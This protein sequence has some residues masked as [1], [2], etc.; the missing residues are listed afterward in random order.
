[1]A[2]QFAASS[3][4]SRSERHALNASAFAGEDF[5]PFVGRMI[6]YPVLSG[7]IQKGFVEAGPSC[8]PSVGL[9]GYRLTSKGWMKFDEVRRTRSQ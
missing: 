6:D 8:R 5:E 9:I 1:M 4:L 2:T 3:K 7:L